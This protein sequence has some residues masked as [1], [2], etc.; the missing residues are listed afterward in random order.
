MSV[1]CPRDSIDVKRTGKPDAGKLH[2][3]FEE[4]ALMMQATFQTRSSRV[5]RGVCIRSGKCCSLALYS[6]VGTTKEQS[7]ANRLK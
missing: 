2:V 3:R 1:G 5:R 6:T 4:G 7:M